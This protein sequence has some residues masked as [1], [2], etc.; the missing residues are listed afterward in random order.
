MGELLKGRRPLWLMGIGAALVIAVVLFEVLTGRSHDQSAYGGGASDSGHVPITSSPGKKPLQPGQG[1]AGGP[2]AGK[3]RR[4]LR[5]GSG[6]THHVVLTISAPSPVATRLGWKVPT[7][8]GTASGKDGYVGASWSHSVTARGDSGLA[9][10]YVMIGDT[11]G[12]VTCTITVD[13]KVADRSS[14]SKP[15][16]S[17]MCIG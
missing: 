6:G 4:A 8:H 9:E 10:L 15:Y 13:G 3:S 14:T 17:I 16:H 1:S 12:A 7:G 5:G 11:K 2:A